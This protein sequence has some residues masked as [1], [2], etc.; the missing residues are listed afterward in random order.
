MS[1]NT[2]NAPVHIHMESEMN[3]VAILEM[4]EKLYD[5]EDLMC[6]LIDTLYGDMD[7]EDEEEYVE[8]GEEGGEKDGEAEEEEICPPA[9]EAIPV[10]LC[11]ADELAEDLSPEEVTDIAK[12][13]L[14]HILNFKPSKEDHHGRA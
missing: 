9:E 14:S 3:R 11:I 13:A 8:D 4:M 5:L 10:I 7:D 6:E 2:F 1:N 12:E